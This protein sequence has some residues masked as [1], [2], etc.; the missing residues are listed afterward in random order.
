MSVVH[1]SDRQLVSTWA[2]GVEGAVIDAGCG[3]GQWTQFLHEL[4]LPVRGVD[5]VP[6]FIEHARRAHPDVRFDLDDLDALDV[7]T[8]T[9]GGVLA[10]Y[11]LIHHEPGTIRIPLREFNRALGPGGGLLIGFFEG[12]AV[13]RFDHAVVPAYRW[14]VTDLAE[15]LGAAGFDV[16]ETHV[17]TTVGQRPQAAISARRRDAGSS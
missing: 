8:G 12:P 6:E 13:E 11:S 10:W 15:E 4:G 9:V 1:P 2:G 7:E 14:S 5:R 3:P 16:I 17:R